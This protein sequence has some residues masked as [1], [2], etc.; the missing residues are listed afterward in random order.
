MKTTNPDHP[1][2]NTLKHL[3]VAVAMA[4]GLLA[5]TALAAPAND[6]FAN[7]I[8]LTGVA[9][10]QTGNN[11]TGTQTGTGN[12]AATLE[13][14]EPNPGS[15]NTVWFKWTCPA[16]GFF[17]YGTLG[18]RNG[19]AGEWDAIIGIYTG[20]A[21]NA[22]SPLGATPKDTVLEESM[23]ISVTNGTTYHIQL[24]GYSGEAAANILL[25]WNFVP[26]GPPILT[27][28]I[29]VNIDTEVR[30]FLGGPAGGLGSIW[31]TIQTGNLATTSV[32]NLLRASGTATTV[33]LNIPYAPGNP[34]VTGGGLVWG[35]D[36]WGSPSLLLLQ[37]GAFNF[38]TGPENTQR[39]EIT[40]LD[41]A[42]T[43]G[44]YIASANC[45]SS[46]RSRGVWYTTNTTST[47]GNHPCDNTANIIGDSWVLGNNYVLVE[48]VVP[49]GSGKITV[50][51][52]ST[53]GYRLPLSGFQLVETKTILEIT[54][55]SYD[56][57]NDQLTLVWDSVPGA[58]YTIE[59]TQQFVANGAGTS[60]DNLTTGIP[61]GG[62]TTTKVIDA[63]SPG[64]YYRIRKE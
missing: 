41:P 14:D 27:F 16:D 21:L 20:A 1:I 4:G 8:A 33:G 31:N 55:I 11:I 56:A 35:V 57:N 2:R 45:L 7:A 10:G 54:S 53:S 37:A 50:D 43:Y 32:P 62:K 18:S 39:F 19:A 38:Q 17:T 6:N 5:G 44:L 34:D 52:Y 26:I 15:A 12:I 30:P 61:S 63:P 22:L 58:T 49:D 28:M 51:G 23:T 29:N 48:D 46:Q 36:P 47:P 42:K 3:A 60:W 25:K 64:T 13:V 40:G 24:A 9:A 59:N